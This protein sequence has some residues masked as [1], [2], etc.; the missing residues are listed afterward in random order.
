[1]ARER[2][3]LDL[4]GRPT[5]E[6]L[7]VLGAV[8]GECPELVLKA[9]AGSHVLLARLVVAAELAL[10]AG[11][12]LGAGGRVNLDGDVTVGVADALSLIHI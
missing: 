7:A 11:S 12:E 10:E 2:L 8:V 5:L 9:R 4:L 6:L 3:C 1:M